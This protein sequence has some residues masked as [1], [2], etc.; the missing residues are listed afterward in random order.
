MITTR[1]PDGANKLT[2]WG[3]I[4]GRPFASGLRKSLV[5]GSKFVK[6]ISE[7]SNMLVTAIIMTPLL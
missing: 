1:A 3:K 5:K 7:M 2:G 6:I 4:F